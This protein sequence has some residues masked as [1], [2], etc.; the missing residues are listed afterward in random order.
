MCAFFR[1][2]K[3][4]RKVARRVR[5]AKKRK[6]K[7]AKRQLRAERR[8]EKKLKKAEKKKA[9]QEKKDKGKEAPTPVAD[10]SLAN[11]AAATSA[12]AAT[13]AT[14]ASASGPAGPDDTT[15]S[16]HEPSSIPQ[17]DTGKVLSPEVQAA[18]TRLAEALEGDPNQLERMVNDH[19]ARRYPR[20]IDPDEH[21]ILPRRAI[22]QSAATTAAQVAI[23]M[24]DR[25]EGAQGP[26]ETH[27]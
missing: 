26:P 9:E 22:I 1:K 3:A 14:L 15:G 12:A 4:A 20:E 19:L 23:A 8:K 17:V 21:T 5:K 6:R 25:E 10:G 18:F 24:R 27:I 11:G 7:K 2:A 16:A 13:T